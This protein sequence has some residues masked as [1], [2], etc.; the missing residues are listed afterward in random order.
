MTGNFNDLALG[1]T[2][3][4]HSEN[5]H[6]EVVSIIEDD[7]GDTASCVVEN[8]DGTFVAI[9]LSKCSRVEARLN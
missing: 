3:R 5:I 8:Y 7:C 1:D 4:L 6:G 2:F 9:D